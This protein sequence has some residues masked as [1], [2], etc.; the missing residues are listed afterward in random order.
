MSEVV[1][2]PTEATGPRRLLQKLL[3]IGGEIGH[4]KKDAQNPHHRY[5]YASEKAI[6]EAVYPKFRQHGVFF[7]LEIQ[8]QPFE[9]GNALMVPFRYRFIDAET[10]EEFTGGWLGSGRMGDDKGLYIAITGAIKY[11]LTTHCGIVTGDDPEAEDESPAPR[12]VLAD[13]PPAQREEWVGNDMLA[14]ANCETRVPREDVKVFPSKYD[15]YK[16]GVKIGDPVYR[17]PECNKYVP[18]REAQ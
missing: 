13:E 15:A 9:M 14:C 3:T 6:K 11:A 16:F 2:Q 7:S 10:G 1:F 12:Q 8:G 5:M 18:V 4:L 17:C